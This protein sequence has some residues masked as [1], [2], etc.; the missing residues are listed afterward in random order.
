MSSKKAP[1]TGVGEAV[2]DMV[3]QIGTAIKASTSSN[4]CCEQNNSP[5][6]ITDSRSKC[7][8]QLGELK[9]LR[10]SNL[11]SE[12]EYVANLDYLSGFGLPSA[13][14]PKELQLSVKLGVRGVMA[15]PS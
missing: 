10:D 8:K 9:T 4:Q 5:I 3:Q 11:L 7:Y 13:L 2:V 12:D 15:S 6:R 14:S 1:C